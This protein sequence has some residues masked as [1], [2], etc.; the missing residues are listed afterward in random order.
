M[1][2]VYI[3]QIIPTIKQKWPDFLS[4]NIRIQQDNAKTHINNNDAEFHEAANADG[5]HIKLVQQPANSPD[6]NANDLGF[7]TAIQSLQQKIKCKTSD[8]LIAAVKESFM[9]LEPMTINKVFLSLQ[10]VLTE[11]IKGK[12]HNNFKQPHIGKNALILQGE[13]PGN[14]EVPENLV[15]ESID[16]LKG[17]DKT[18]GLDILME[19]LGIRVPQRGEG[20]PDL[21]L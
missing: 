9:K 4:K 11:I 3:F 14:L 12:G 17:E 16:Y 8:E 20:V 21:N 5:F 7:F 15:R 13:L 1:L 6:C 10:C 2:D 19:E 18:E